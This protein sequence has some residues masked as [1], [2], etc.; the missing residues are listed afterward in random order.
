MTGC[1]GCDRSNRNISNLFSASKNSSH[2]TKQVTV[3]EGQ[4]RETPKNRKK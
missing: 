3:Y 1:M 4:I 2:G